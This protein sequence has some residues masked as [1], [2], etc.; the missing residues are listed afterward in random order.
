MSISVSVSATYN[1]ASLTEQF[2]AT[3]TSSVG[4]DG[5]KVQVLSVGTSSSQISTATIDTLGYCYVRSLVTTT[6]ATC[7]ITLG[8]LASNVLQPM[9]RLRPGDPALFRLAPGDYAV[10]AADDGYRMF[11]AVFED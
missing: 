7:T 9:V 8:R 3:R 2:S 10:E 6:E 1:S 4:N 11:V 5:Y